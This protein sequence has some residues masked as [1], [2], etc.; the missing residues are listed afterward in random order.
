[1]T[2]EANIIEV[3]ATKF[4]LFVKAFDRLIARARKLGCTLPSF[5]VVSVFSR[6]H[7]TKA[8]KGLPL[9]IGGSEVKSVVVSGPRPK[10]AGWS[11]VAT[12]EP[13]DGGVNLI[14]SIPGAGELDASFRA[15]TQCDHCNKSRNRSATFVVRHEDGRTMRVGRQCIGDFLGGQ[16]PESIALE[17]AL[18]NDCASFGD[19]EEFSSGGSAPTVYPLVPFVAL[20][21]REICTNGWVSRKVAG[22]RCVM[23]S[24]DAA[25][26]RFIGNPFKGIRPEVPNEEEISSAKAAIAWTAA[27][28]GTSDFDHNIKSIA[29][30]G[31]ATGRTI[32]MAAA[33]YGAHQRFLER[34]VARREFARASA[35]S[36]HVGAVKARLDL[37]LSV[38]SV[39][40]AESDFGVTHIHTM[41]DASGNVFKWFASSGCLKIGETYSVRGTVKGHGEYKGRKETILTRCKAEK[42]EKAA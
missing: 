9:C 2:N 37:V 7:F 28:E 6:L 21:I 29:L 35:D 39:F 5:E 13:F 10:F 11:L 17:F 42:K 22:E 3:D 23:A 12:L 30:S 36:A 20:V 38:T 16:S 40:T 31:N 8:E 19:D 32:G 1:M 18:A 15:G 33:I 41:V 25:L 34:E 24:A 4:P 27:L 26:D 14:R